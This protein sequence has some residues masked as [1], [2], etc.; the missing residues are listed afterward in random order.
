MSMLFLSLRKIVFA[1]NFAR[2]VK[3][4]T[5]SV[6]LIERSVHAS[7]VNGSDSSDYESQ[8]I[9]TQ[10]LMKHYEQKV[11]EDRL[12]HDELAI[13]RA[14]MKAIQVSNC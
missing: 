10:Q 13:H 8:Q 1:N 3:N 14:H 6:L 4:K 7:G 9:S 11:D 2:S 12:T 5:R